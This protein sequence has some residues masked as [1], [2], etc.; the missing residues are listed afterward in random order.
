MNHMLRSIVSR[1][2]FSAAFSLIELAMV[3]AVSGL[4]VGFLLQANTQS[5]GG[6]ECTTATKIQLSTIRAAVEQFARK[7]DRLPLPAARNVGG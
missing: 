2:K 6:T 4:M 5:S 1:N 3:L 7:N